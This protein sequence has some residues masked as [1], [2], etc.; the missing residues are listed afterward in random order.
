MSTK[1]PTRTTG[2]C[3]ARWRLHLAATQ[4][5]IRLRVRHAERERIARELHDTLLQST[6]GLILG[7]Q[8][9]T[10]SLPETDHTRQNIEAQ[11]DGADAVVGETRNRVLE[12]RKA[13][14][15]DT[16]LLQELT[17]AGTEFSNGGPVL[18]SAVNV[19]EPRALAAVVSEEIFL[20]TCEAL[21][22]AFA[23]GQANHVEVEVHY[24]RRALRIRVSDDGGGIDPTV[25][26]AGERPG[27]WG[28]P[29]MRERAQ[30]IGATVNIASVPGKGTRVE[31]LVPG[32]IA[33]AP[34]TP[35]WWRRP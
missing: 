5:Q 15:G 26:A 22:N 11:L 17:T 13:M 24:E 2:T 9:A 31:L 8:A 29:G 6:Q 25:L 23:H 7:L 18:F 28:L 4:A 21:R 27:H 1:K 14:A 30:Q 20:I 34:S 10:S 33:Y 16:E 32:R 19:G 12:L 3:C 35:P